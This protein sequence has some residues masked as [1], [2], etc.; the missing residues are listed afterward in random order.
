MN[1][2]CSIH[3]FKEL[4]R[5]SQRLKN[6]W[7]MKVRSIVRFHRFANSF[8]RK[9][10]L[11]GGNLMA[12]CRSKV[13]I[14]GFWRWP[15][16]PTS[17]NL[18]LIQEYPNYSGWTPSLFLIHSLLLFF[19]TT[20][21]STR[22][23]LKNWPLMSLLCKELVKQKSKKGLKMEYLCMVFTWKE[24]DGIHKTKKLL[25]NSQGEQFQNCRLSILYRRKRKIL[26]LVTASTVPFIRFKK[27]KEWVREP[28]ELGTL[29]CIWSCHQVK[30]GKFGLKTGL[31]YS[32]R[33]NIDLHFVNFIN[34]L[35][36]FYGTKKTIYPIC[37]N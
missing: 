21:E 33:R 7:R 36:L 18:G 20:V 3:W 29:S 24:Q 27:G 16:V 13:F 37:K 19:K 8:L 6:S 15:T 9:K 12:S 34:L 25:H 32:S 17:S 26:Q 2:N 35:Y 14:L 1:S 4:N 10:C 28:E 23:L 5:V 22:L 30:F 31:P 11:N